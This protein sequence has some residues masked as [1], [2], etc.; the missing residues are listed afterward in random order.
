[1]VSMKIIC[2]VLL[3]YGRLVEDQASAAHGWMVWVLT[4]CEG[5]QRRQRKAIA[6]FLLVIKLSILMKA[7]LSFILRLCLVFDLQSLFVKTLQVKT[8]F[9]LWYQ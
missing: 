1:M 8:H 2:G 5:D 6:S 4:K 7:I 9:I 3:W